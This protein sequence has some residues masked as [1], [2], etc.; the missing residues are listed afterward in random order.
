[1]LTSFD[2]G[3]GRLTLD[4]PRRKNAIT[5]EMA[6]AIE[7]FCDQVV[8]DETIGAVVVDATGSYFCSG[9]DTRILAGARPIRRR[10]SR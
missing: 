9:A 7:R 4:N 6:A 1:M 3:I 10:R 8:D 2:G 5:L